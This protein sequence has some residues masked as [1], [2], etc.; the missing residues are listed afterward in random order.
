MRSA[1]LR[2]IVA[3]DDPGM[4]AMLNALLDGD[5]RIDLVASAADADEAID[6]AR[7][8]QPDVCVVDVGMPGGGGP[9]AARGIRAACPAARLVALSGR[10]DRET[11]VEMLRAGVSGYVVKGATAEEI[12]DAIRRVGRGQRVLSHAVTS[13]VIDELS[14]R[15]DR[16]ERR[17]NR[18]RGIAKR[19]DAVLTE[20]LLSMVFQPICRL[21][22]QRPVGF[23]A[24]ARF[25]HAR[26]QGPDVWFAE[27]AEVGRLLELE[28][29]AVRSALATLPALSPSAFLAINVSPSTL[30]SPELLELVRDC[31][32]GDRLVIEATEHAPISD[33]ELAAR[34]LTSLRAAGVRLAV[35]DAGA[36]FASL[37]HIVRLGP[38]FIKV[39]G[40][41][42][43]QVATDRGQRALTKALI[44]FAQETEALIVAEGLETDD[45][46]AAVH[47]LG[48]ALGQGYGLGRPGPIH[49]A[50]GL[51]RSR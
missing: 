1:S 51:A 28:L 23:E 22:A 7:E 45:Q 36:G 6:A 40:E 21:P 3:E 25:E 37:R 11:V 50:R 12:L 29:T 8:H 13:G 17:D 42:T 10:E 39:D 2:V 16:D 4:R 27:A 33:Y 32:S 47:Q 41:I 34:A 18:L 43:R 19:I 14:A 44:A 48:V 35:D 26:A 5:E 9:H 30:C 49:A 15:L 46:I 20:G 24:L 38:E 31:G